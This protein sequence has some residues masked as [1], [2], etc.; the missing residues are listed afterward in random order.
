MSVASIYAAIVPCL[1]PFVNPSTSGKK[2]G[3]SAKRRENGTRKKIRGED[4]IHRDN[5]SSETTTLT[6]KNYFR[7]E[8]VNRSSKLGIFLFFFFFSPSFFNRVTRYPGNL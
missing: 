4:S 2:E 1:L 6:M 5:L 8:F 3:R 7:N